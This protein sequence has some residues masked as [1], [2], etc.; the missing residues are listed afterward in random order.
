MK[1]RA[2]HC[3]NIGLNTVKY[4]A[5]YRANKVEYKTNAEKI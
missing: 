1:Y 3:E 4:R 5:Q 2:Q